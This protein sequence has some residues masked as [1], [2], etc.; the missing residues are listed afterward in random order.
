MLVMG[1][2]HSLLSIPV[3]VSCYILLG[4]RV[5]VGVGLRRPSSVPVSA[6]GVLTIGGALPL[7]RPQAAIRVRLRIWEQGQ[8][9]TEWKGPNRDLTVL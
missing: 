7:R 8:N 5:G 2:V 9:M 3:P 4:F 1:S 6:E